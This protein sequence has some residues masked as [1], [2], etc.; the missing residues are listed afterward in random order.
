MV[1]IVIKKEVAPG[2]IFY[3]NS[4]SNNKMHLDIEE[5]VSSE[6][7]FWKNAQ[8]S[9]GY[10]KDIRDT[11]TI[12]VPYS[13][14][15]KDNS[16]TP[17]D[18]FFQSV[19]NLF[20]KDI[21]IIEQDYMKNFGIFFESHYN[22]ELLRYSVGQNFASHIDDHTNYHRRISIV[23]YFN[24]DYQGGEIEFPWFN[25]K[26]KPEANST[27]IFPS[28]YVYRHSVH[29]VTDGVRYSMASWIK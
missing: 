14:E 4:L 3:K 9:G 19:S 24:D 13:K 12:T 26:I 17:L 27:L 1:G 15:Y 2:I 8:V 16:E 20:L 7:V 29:P 11:G 25:L 23:H 10:N 21:G 28:N 6:I 5:A 18:E 22:Y